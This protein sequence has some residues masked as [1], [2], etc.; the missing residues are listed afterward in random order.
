MSKKESSSSKEILEQL[1]IELALRDDNQHVGSG[2]GGNAAQFFFLLSHKVVAHLV[3]EPGASFQ[4]SHGQIDFY[5]SSQ[6][7][8][9]QIRETFKVFFDS[10]PDKN[11]YTQAQV[12][13]TSFLRD[14]MVNT[15]DV[16]LL[17]Q[18]LEVGHEVVSWLDPKCTLVSQV[19]ALFGKET[20]AF[21][22]AFLKEMSLPVNYFDKDS[23]DREYDDPVMEMFKAHPIWGAKY[24]ASSA[25]ADQII[26]DLVSQED[27]DKLRFIGTCPSYISLFAFRN[28]LQIDRLVTLNLD[29][30]L[31]C[32][33]SISKKTNS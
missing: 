24:K 6:A 13:N 20:A 19:H 29:E 5:V 9:K 8:M 15:I 21:E 12:S 18:A 26:K 3:D 7:S 25:R 22:K 32:F 10:H 17:I 4:R 11:D 30:R 2:L 27:L 31:N 1:K 28:T 33:D 23:I 16:N 14:Q